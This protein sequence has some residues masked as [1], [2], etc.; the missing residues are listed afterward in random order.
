MMKST[1]NKVLSGLLLIAFGLVYSGC[2]EIDNPVIDYGSYR[3]D[4]Y[5]PPPTFTPV[6]A[7]H[8]KV[9]LEDFT[10]H[11]CGNCP[12]G[13][14]KAAELLDQYGDDLAVVAVHAGSLGAPFPPDFPSDWTTPEGEYYLLTQVGQDVM[15]KGRTNRIADA[16]VIHSPSAWPAKVAES[17]EVAP[18]VNLQMSVSYAPDNQH[19]NVHVNSQWF[20]TLTGD[21]RLVIMITEGEIVAPQLW[22]NH[23][24]EYNPDYLHEHMLRTTITGATGLVLVSNPQA[25]TSQTKSYT[26]DWNTEWVPEH[27]EVIAF[28]TEGEDGRVL[29][30]QKA[31]VI[32]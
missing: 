9:L 8:R 11:D 28:I 22:Y 6:D 3:A 23:D 2:D 17:F 31:T 15:P 21:Y 13:H 29:N 19:L 12:N 14:I 18:E 5:G 4:L 20:E 26:Y 7:P 1:F 27:C 32:P 10:G 24:P 25:G 16:S 30:V